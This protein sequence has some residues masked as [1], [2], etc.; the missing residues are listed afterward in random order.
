M[1]VDSFIRAVLFVVFV[2]VQNW[3][4]SYFSYC[5]DY[6]KLKR[7]NNLLY[8]HAVDTRGKEK[9]EVNFLLTKQGNGTAQQAVGPQTNGL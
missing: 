1:K 8:A 7:E 2:S 4:L 3:Q 9:G 5:C 6:P